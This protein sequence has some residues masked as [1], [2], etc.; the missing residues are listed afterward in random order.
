MPGRV[1]IFRY[2]V[3]DAGLTVETVEP[4]FFFRRQ[5]GVEEFLIWRLTLKE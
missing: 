1:I 4:F 5:S 2:F 3:K